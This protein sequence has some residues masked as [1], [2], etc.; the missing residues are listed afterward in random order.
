MEIPELI[1][2]FVAIFFLTGVAIL[3]G[4]LIRTKC[5]TTAL[6]Q[7]KERRN[8]MPG[9]VPFLL[10]LIWIGFSSGLIGLVQK[11]GLF[12][13]FDD[14]QKT[15]INYLFLGIVEITMIFLMLLTGWN[16]FARRL[17]GFGFAKKGLLRD[18]GWAAVA[19][20]AVAPV[21]ELLVRAVLVIGKFFA[22]ENFQMQQNEGIADILACDQLS[23]KVAIFIFS[24][25]IVPF[26][27]EML[28]RGIIQS[29]LRGL[30]K[31]PWL[32]IFL[33]SVVFTTLHPAMHW[34]ALLAFSLALGYVYEKSSSLWRPIIMHSLFNAIN[35]TI[36]LINQ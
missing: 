14:W 18:A 28:F 2:Y 17:R 12:S 3:T 30:L 8:S 25:F 7:T 35:L 34:P 10:I 19:L 13:A 27:E 23:V 24:V 6:S 29:Y 11:T 4:W 15:L 16:Y 5:G 1:N 26:F 31:K 36:T 21:V 9:P 32:A 20:I 33:T 22:G